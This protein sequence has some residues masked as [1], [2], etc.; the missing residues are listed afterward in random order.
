LRDNLHLTLVF[1]G[2]IAHDKIPLLERIAGEQQVSAFDFPFGTTGY[3]PHNRI[4][5]AAPHSIPEPLRVLVAALERMLS[6]AGFACDR[7]AY[8]PHVTLLR[9]AG[10]P[11]ILPPLACD[12]PV[13]GF[14]LTESVR[15]EEGAHYRTLSQWPLDARKNDSCSPAL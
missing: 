15:T 6:R 14:T 8:S 9:N 7:C 1:L 5:W 10:A 4:V 13:T 11:A 3:W 12:W 2:A